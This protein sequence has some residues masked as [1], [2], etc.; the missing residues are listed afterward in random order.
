MY[1]IACKTVAMY[2]SNS[3]IIRLQWFYTYPVVLCRATADMKD[4]SLWKQISKALMDIML[5]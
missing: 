5:G 4:M 3:T 1:S 2:Y